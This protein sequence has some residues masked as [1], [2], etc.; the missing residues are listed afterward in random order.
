M[1]WE[2]IT[3]ALQFTQQEGETMTG[4]NVLL[5]CPA[6]LMKAVDY[7]LRGVL[8]K[9]DDFE[10]TG[11]TECATMPN[12]GMFRVTLIDKVSVIGG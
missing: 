9:D 2:V 3:R 6:E 12:Q 11:V 7:Y 4:N 10:V 1:R 5:L 8:F